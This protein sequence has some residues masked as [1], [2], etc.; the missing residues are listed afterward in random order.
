MNTFVVHMTHLLYYLVSISVQEVQEINVMCQL[1]K[2]LLSMNMF[3]LSKVAAIYELHHAK[4][5]LEVS[6]KSDYSNQHLNPCGLDLVSSCT[7]TSL[8]NTMLH[9]K[10]YFRFDGHS[11]SIVRL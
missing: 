1:R 6:A 5:E 7:M 2:I 4:M 8:I 10:T 9:F 11:R 3:Y